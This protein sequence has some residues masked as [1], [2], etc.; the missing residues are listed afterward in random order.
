MS[1]PNETTP[2]VFPYLE[3][4]HQHAGSDMFFS[5]GSPPHIKLEGHAR[6]W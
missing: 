4:L 3:L 5:V 6:P 2:S 1:D